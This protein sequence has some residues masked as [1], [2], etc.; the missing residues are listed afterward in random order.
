MPGK[1]SV[2]RVHGGDER[3]NPLF[4]AARASLPSDFGTG[5]FWGR[6]HLAG[7]GHAVAVHTK[8]KGDM[9]T[10]WVSLVSLARALR[11]NV[12]ETAVDDRSPG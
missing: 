4:C 12:L 11:R 6:D 10:A 7:S 9:Y 8:R 3:L 1:V 5:S 2:A